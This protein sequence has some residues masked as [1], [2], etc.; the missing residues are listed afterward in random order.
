MKISLKVSGLLSTFALTMIVGTNQARAMDL[1]WS[2]QFRSEAVMINNYAPDPATGWLGDGYT[3]APSGTKNARFQTLFLRLRPKLIVNDNVAIKSEWWLGNPITG[4]YGAD[5]P[6]STRTDQTA[7]NST[8]S[9]GSTVSAQP[10]KPTKKKIKTAFKKTNR[11]SIID[12]SL[13]S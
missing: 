3:V 4:F 11:K 6:G 2:G 8:F 7:Y 5:Y 9:G 10:A 12:L 1:D 13:Y